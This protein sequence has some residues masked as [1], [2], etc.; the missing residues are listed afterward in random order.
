MWK[1]QARFDLI[2]QQV[3]DGQFA[4][5]GTNLDGL[6]ETLGTIRSRIDQLKKEKPGFACTITFIGTPMDK[7]MKRVA[8]LETMAKQWKEMHLIVSGNG[9]NINTML[10]KTQMVFSN[11]ILKS[12]VKNY[13]DWANAVPSPGDFF[14]AVPVKLQGLLIPGNIMEWYGNAEEDANILK[15]QA[16]SIKRMS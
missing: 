1:L 3:L 12:V 8:A 11:N 2:S 15:D 6:Q 16:L 9:Q 7:G 14:G 13:L 10:L 5:A 4:L